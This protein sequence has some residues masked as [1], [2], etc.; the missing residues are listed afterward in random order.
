[1]LSLAALHGIEYVQCMQ[2]RAEQ[3]ASQTEI[4]LIVFSAK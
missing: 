3:A 2:Q 1:M 4:K